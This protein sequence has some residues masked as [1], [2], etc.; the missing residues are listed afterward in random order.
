MPSFFDKPFE[1]Q[2]EKIM[3]IENAEGLRLLQA[4]IGV[5]SSATFI[6]Y[7]SGFIITK[8]NIMYA[9]LYG[10]YKLKELC[11]EE[12]K[13]V[14]DAKFREMDEDIM[15]E[16]VSKDKSFKDRDFDKIIPDSVGLR[17]LLKEVVLESF[18]IGITES[19]NQ[20]LFQTTDIVVVIDRLLSMCVIRI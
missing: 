17:K 16:L 1:E 8:I 13:K 15:G 4:L 14:L 9:R 20:L 11:L 6:K 12:Y 18:R 5:R 10:E 19:K 2:V 3:K 7:Y